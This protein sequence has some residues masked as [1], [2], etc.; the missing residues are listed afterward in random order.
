MRAVP[1]EYDSFAWIYNQNWRYFAD[2]VIPIVDAL[3]LEHLR[4]G[5]RILDVC[6]GA[7][8]L[9]AALMRSGA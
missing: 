4:P 3:V 2:Q 6:C 9:A 8:H 1:A 5:A 7:G